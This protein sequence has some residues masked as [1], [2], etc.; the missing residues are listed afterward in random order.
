MRQAA[1]AGVVRGQHSGMRIGIGDVAQV[2]IV[3]VD[4]A[5][6]ELGLA[7]REIKGR[8]R[9]QVQDGQPAQQQGG[10]A[11]GK[12]QKQGKHKQQP[13]AQGRQSKHQ[14]RRGGQSRDFNAN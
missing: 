10:A 14:P 2:Y 7:I 3:K 6:R 11:G 4:L 5:R 8:G 12:H 13:Q 1:L 9:K